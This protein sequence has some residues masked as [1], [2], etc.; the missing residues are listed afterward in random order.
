MNV[1]ENK[2]LYKYSPLQTFDV[3]FLYPS[4]PLKANQFKQTSSTVSAQRSDINFL[5]QNFVDGQK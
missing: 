2:W 3:S 5:R 1:T 4:L